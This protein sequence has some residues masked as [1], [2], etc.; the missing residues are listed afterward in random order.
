MSRP[1]F[2]PLEILAVL[3]KHRVAY[4]VIGRLAGIIHGTGGI[5]DGIEICP[6][7]K[8][9]N[10]ARLQRALAEL[11]AVSAD[12]PPLGAPPIEVASALGEIAITAEPAG[13]RGGWDDL[14][15]R[16]T[17]EPLGEGVRAPIAA[18]EDLIRIAAATDSPEQALN[19]ATLRRVAELDR[20]RGRGM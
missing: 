6:Q 2:E 10:L 13:T 5:A 20:S 1:P 15:R 12:A 8:D 17:R 14:R 11:G 7:M 18:I 3:E 19:L 4:V 9:A 16:A